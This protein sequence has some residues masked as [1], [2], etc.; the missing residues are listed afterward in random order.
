MHIPR[1]QPSR[2]V[3]T[4]YGFPRASAV[5]KCRLQIKATLTNSRHHLSQCTIGRMKTICFCGL[6]QKSQ[7]KCYGSLPPKTVRVSYNPEPRIP[8]SHRVFHALPS[9]GRRAPIKCQPPF[10]LWVTVSSEYSPSVILYSV[11]ICSRVMWTT[12]SIAPT[13]RKVTGK[14]SVFF[15]QCYYSWKTGRVTRSVLQVHYSPGYY[16]MEMHEEELKIAG[17]LSQLLTL[18]LAWKKEGSKD[19]VNLSGQMWS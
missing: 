11:T 5:D 17:Q 6:I 13:R 2:G 10:E 12:Y 14:H 3:H 15:T 19:W 16:G 18:D 7:E 1:T 4:W 9:A 8:L